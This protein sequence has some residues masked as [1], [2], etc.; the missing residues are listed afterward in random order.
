MIKKYKNYERRNEIF[1]SYFS[2]KHTLVI[3]NNVKVLHLFCSF[4]LNMAQELKD[5]V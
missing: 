1:L 2:L 3:L 5:V 4:Q